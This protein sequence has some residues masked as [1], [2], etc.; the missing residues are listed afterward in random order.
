MN[1]ILDI[2]Q[3]NINKQEVRSIENTQAE[4]QRTKKYRK[5]RKKHRKY[6]KHVV[7]F[8]IWKIEFWERVDRKLAKTNVWTNNS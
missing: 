8:N 5:Y 7:R 2:A 3:N 4:E 6:M 1:C